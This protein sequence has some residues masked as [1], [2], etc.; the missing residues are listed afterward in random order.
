MVN[1]YFIHLHDQLPLDELLPY[2]P[3]DFIQKIQKFRY[4]KD[5][6]ASL[7]GRL[8]LQYG[9][10]QLTGGTLAFEA[11][12]YGKAGKP[13]LANSPIQFNISHSHQMVVCAIA[14]TFPI[15]IDIEYRKPIDIADFKFQM[16][17]REW[18][19]IHTATDQ[20][21]AFYQYWTKKEA[22]MK[23]TGKGFTL[24]LQSFEVL[25]TAPATLLGDIKWYFQ[26]IDSHPDYSCHLTTNPSPLTSYSCHQLV[27][28]DIQALFSS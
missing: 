22:V 1:V 25:P 11:I 19:A 26:R 24:P 27:E 2:F 21:K 10:Q 14:D 17:E 3:T 28:S 16:T 23:A 9:Y 6:L 8:L 5:A 7:Y 12:Q 13:F 18:T 20:L 15:G 4:R